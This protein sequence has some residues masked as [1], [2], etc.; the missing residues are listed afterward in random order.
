MRDKEFTRD[1]I[2]RADIFKDSSSY[3]EYIMRRDLEG[4]APRG[5]IPFILN[6]SKDPFAAELLLKD[7]KKVA[8]M[9]ASSMIAVI[10]SSIVCGVAVAQLNS[11]GSLAMLLGLFASLA[12]TAVVGI[13]IASW[14]LA[15]TFGSDRYR[16]IKLS[17]AT[18][19]RE[20][21]FRQRV[22][23]MLSRLE[24]ISSIIAKP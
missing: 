5:F 18:A 4:L 11:F 9:E 1:D 19:E 13:I 16:S 3:E 20:A 12:I 10:T 7:P 6:P 14:S 15:R 23:D 24:S 17:Q 2:R 8:I 22:N 21:A